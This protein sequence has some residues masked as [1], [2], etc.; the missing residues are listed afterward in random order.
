MR[1]LLKRV[2]K[3]TD[4][5]VQSSMMEEWYNVI[6]ETYTPQIIV[7]VDQAGKAKPVVETRVSKNP[8]RGWYKVR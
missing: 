3:K 7:P 6:V 8:H 4:P 1:V 5:K 2:P